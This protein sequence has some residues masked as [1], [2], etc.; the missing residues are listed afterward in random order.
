MSP[1]TAHLKC[2]R[3]GSPF[4]YEYV[5]GA[6]FTGL[7]LAGRRY[8]R[9]PACHQFTIFDLREGEPAG[10]A[11]TLGVPIYSDRQH[12]VR[13]LAIFLVPAVLVETV[14][15][16]ILPRPEPA[17]LVALAGVA[18]IAAGSLALMIVGSPPRRAPTWG[19]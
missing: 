16:V 18:V 17:L 12:V 10:T 11:P 8:M 1:P 14:L 6:S 19:P 13:W 5:P 3:C 15:A 2:A 7:R 4:D 9:C